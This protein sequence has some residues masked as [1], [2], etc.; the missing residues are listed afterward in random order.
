MRHQAGREELAVYLVREG[1]CRTSVVARRLARV[2]A[3]ARRSWPTRGGGLRGRIAGGWQPRG[4]C[5]G[6][7]GGEVRLGRRS[8]GGRS[9]NKIEAS[10]R[11][12]NSGLRIADCLDVDGDADRGELAFHGLR[13]L[14]AHTS[15]SVAM[16]TWR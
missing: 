13:P 5:R 4:V 7:H 15:Q 2:P 14:Q 6:Q 12:S 3:A 1:G 11:S 10:V 9:F 16:A 8:L